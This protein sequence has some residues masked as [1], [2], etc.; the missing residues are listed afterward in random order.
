MHRVRTRQAQFQAHVG[1]TKTGEQEEDVEEKAATWGRPMRVHLVGECGAEAGLCLWE[2]VEKESDARTEPENGTERIVAGRS[3][4]KPSIEDDSVND[5][6]KGIDGT[7]WL[8]RGA[9]APAPSWFWT[10]NRQGIFGYEAVHP[11]SCTHHRT[12]W[13]YHHRSVRGLIEDGSSWQVSS[14]LRGE[15]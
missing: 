3:S 11:C 7:S 13:K 15:Y 9:D 2:C 1:S 10:G 12:K 4:R 14:R 8:K 5:D 6:A